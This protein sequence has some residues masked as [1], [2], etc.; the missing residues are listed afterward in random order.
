M[1]KIF[2]AKNPCE[3]PL[4][5]LFHNFIGKTWMIR[6]NKATEIPYKEYNLPY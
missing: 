5:I 1:G 6:M 2:E 4:P 3:P